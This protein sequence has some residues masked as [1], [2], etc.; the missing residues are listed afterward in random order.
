[1]SLH[2]LTSY[3][4]K[5]I[6]SVYPLSKLYINTYKD[7]VKKEAESANVKNTDNIL[8]IGGGAIP[9]T[10]II[11]A[12][13][14]KGVTIID[15]DKK[16]VKLANKLIEKLKLSNIKY[17]YCK[18]EDIVST[19]FTKIFVPLQAEPKCK[20]LANIKASANENAEVIIRLPK[21]K[22]ARTYTPAC[23]LPIKKYK[24]KDET[25]HLTFNKTLCCFAKD[26]LNNEARI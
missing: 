3:F 4:E 25:N 9:Y 7:A 24:I 19:S 17:Y 23:N 5:L 22:Y 21:E 12:E 14:A 1:M 15:M 26:I 2:S 18:G 16:A 8:I 11:M 20:I 13:L 10:G 6:A